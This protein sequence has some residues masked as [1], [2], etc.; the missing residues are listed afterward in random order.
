MKKRELN[1]LILCST[2][3]GIILIIFRYFLTSDFR[4]NLKSRSALYYRAQNFDKTYFKIF[5]ERFPDMIEEDAIIEIHE[6]KNTET[7]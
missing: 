1:S 3:D 5:A 7:V 2:I 6:V 4:R